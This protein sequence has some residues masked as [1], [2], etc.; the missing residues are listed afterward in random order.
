MKILHVISGL[1]TGGAELFLER[2]ALGLADQN[3]NQTIVALRYAGAAAARL[4]RAGIHVHAL[5]AGL[6]PAGLRALFTLRG[7]I[8]EQAPDLI[9][10]WLYHGNLGASLARRLGGCA[11]PVVWNVRHSLDGWRQESPVLRGLIRLGSAVSGSAERIVFNSAR[12]VRQHAA[13]GYP[14]A[15]SVVIPNGFDCQEFH[16]DPELRQATRQQLGFEKDAVVIGMVASYRPV[17]D[18]VTFLAAAR[19]LLDAVPM[20]RFLLVG[21]DADSRHPAFRNLLVKHQLT[22]HVRALGER[23]DMPALLNAMD[24][25]VSSSWAEGFPNAVGEAMACGVPCVVTD[26]GAS[27]ELVGNT[28]RVVPARAPEALAAALAEQVQA[29]QGLRAKLGSAARERIV[30]NYEQGAIVQRYADFYRTFSHGH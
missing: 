15:K 2:L 14:E 13:R 21:K 12:A 9:Q 5:H 4:E 30:R 3:C 16:P 8:R 7:L 11:C 6:N 29:G 22:E 24:L 25:A 1:D 17:K 18:H 28:G 10:G 20:A 23:E 27:A 26:V 19:R